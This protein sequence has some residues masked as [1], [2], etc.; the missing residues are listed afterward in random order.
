MLLII[1]PALFPVVFLFVGA[2]VAS[3]FTSSI[4]L[5][6][7]MYFGVALLCYFNC[8][9]LLWGYKLEKHF[10]VKIGLWQPFTAEAGITENE[11]IT[12]FLVDIDVYS[13]CELDLEFGMPVM[14][15]IRG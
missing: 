14:C 7:Y 13:I 11:Q 15:G 9:L 5:I 1:R 10:R 2:L 8:R 3:T 4:L 6:S 12:S